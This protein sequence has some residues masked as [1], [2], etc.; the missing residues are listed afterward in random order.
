MSSDVIG[1][2]LHWSICASIEAGRNTLPEITQALSGRLGAAMVPK[3]LANMVQSG[4]LQLRDGVY[5]LTYKGRD[6]L[7]PR[8]STVE[9]PAYQPPKAA[10]RRPGAD[11]FRS[12]PSLYAGVAR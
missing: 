9:H 11:D 7:G 8:G 3:T 5:R 12:I 10:P 4:H 1:G 6:M 2:R